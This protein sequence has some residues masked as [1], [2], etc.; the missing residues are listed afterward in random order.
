MVRRTM[1]YGSRLGE[2]RRCLPAGDLKRAR[3]SGQRTGLKILLLL[4]SPV[5]D[6]PL[7]YLITAT[8]FQPLYGRLSDMFGRRKAFLLATSTFALGCLLCGLAQSMVVLN[9][10]RAL[11]GVG[12]GGLMTMAT[13]VLSDGVPFH[14]RGLYQSANNLMYGLGS[15]AGASVGGI[16]AHAFGWRSAFLLQVP[17]AIAAVIGGW[18]LVK[19]PGVRSLP[20]D[21]PVDVAGSATLVGAITLLLL[22]LSMGGNELDWTSP[23]TIA[24]FIAALLLFGLFYRIETRAV[25][26]ILPSRMLKGTLAVSNILTNFTS[27]M[28]VYGFLFMAPMYFLGV[29]LEPINVVGL[30]LIVPSLGFPIGAVIA[31]VVMSK[32]GHLS[33]LVKSGCAV[34]VVGLVIPWILFGET[35]PRT[36]IVYLFALLPAN[37]GQGLINPSSLFTML[38]AYPHDDQAVATSTVYLCR[39]IG[40]VAGVALSSAILQSWLRTW[41]P[42]VLKGTQDADQVSHLGQD[43][44]ANTEYC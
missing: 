15:A 25:A 42:E 43:S 31:G 21:A 24:L 33:V 16:V 28:A 1:R 2:D 8:A 11:T 17:M 23:I 14:R 12:G 40:N 41:L 36:N 7:S 44:L 18:A 32:Y 26:P 22:G 27:G 3:G 5:L 13:I 9:L 30:R 6:L 39:S 20:A 34:L 29:L 38:A 35:E 37:I 4:T 19:D 10:S